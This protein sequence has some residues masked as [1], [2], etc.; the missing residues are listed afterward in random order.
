[1]TYVDGCRTGPT[2]RPYPAAVRR[3]EVTAALT[4]QA[5]ASANLDIS[6]VT[7]PGFNRQMTDAGKNIELNVQYH[8]WGLAGFVRSSEGV[9]DS[10]ALRPGG[11]DGGYQ[12]SWRR[13]IAGV[14]PAGPVRIGSPEPA[15]WRT[16]AAG[17]AILVKDRRSRGPNTAMCVRLHPDRAAGAST[18]VILT[19]ADP[20]CTA[21]R[22]VACRA[23]SAAASRRP[24][25]GRR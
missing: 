11:A 8:L 7:D 24:R 21:A 4:D 25:V 14:R 18:S 3:Q 9:P 20:V 6:L 16:R 5:L 10:G 13:R 15:P 12:R 19:H 17:P 23:C 22:V 2:V 1:M